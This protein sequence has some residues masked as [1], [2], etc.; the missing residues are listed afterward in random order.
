MPSPGFQIVTRGIPAQA[1]EWFRAQNANLADLPQLSD[2]DRR[3][4]KARRMTDEQYARHLVLR[5]SARERETEEAERL[6]NAIVE[7]LQ[8]F[9]TDFHLK[10]IERRGLEPGWHVLIEFHPR[11]ATHKFFDIAL[12]TEDYSGDRQAEVLNLSDI[13]QIRG[14]LVARLG[15]NELGAVAS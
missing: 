3:R 12:L 1:E 8:Q 6:G 14:F 9:G 2:E 5:A 13:D 15:I 11:G 7:I 4:A 10:G